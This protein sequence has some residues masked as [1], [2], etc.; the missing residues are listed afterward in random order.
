MFGLLCLSHEIVFR[1]KSDCTLR[2]TRCW[3]AD[4][5]TKILLK[6]IQQVTALMETRFQQIGADFSQFN[7]DADDTLDQSGVVSLLHYLIPNLSAVSSWGR[8]S[9]VASPCASL[10]E[11]VCIAL[12]LRRVDVLLVLLLEHLH[13]PH[14]WGLLGSLRVT[15]VGALA[16]VDVRRW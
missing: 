4:S 8:Y 3:Q 10:A 5:G 13:V 7:P 14:A 2:R 16:F 11:V 6:N 9:C 1:E 15:V 12:P